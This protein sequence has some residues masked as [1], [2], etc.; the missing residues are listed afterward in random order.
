MGRHLARW[1]AAAA[2]PRLVLLGRTNRTPAAVLL[3]AELA[4]CGAGPRS[5]PATSPTG[6]SSAGCWP[7]SRPTDPVPAVFHTAGGPGRAPLAATPTRTA[8]FA[9]SWPRRWR[10]RPTWTTCCRPPARRVRPFLLH[11]R[12]LGQHG[13]AGYAAANAYLDAL[14]DQRR[15]RGRPATAVAWGVWADVVLGDPDTDEEQQAA[16]QPARP[17][18][19]AARAGAGRA[20]AGPGPTTT[21]RWSSPTWTGSGS[22]RCSPRREPGRCS[23]ICPTCSHS[24]LRRRVR[25]GR[26]RGH[27]RRPVGTRRTTGA[28]G[29]SQ[30][31]VSGS[32]A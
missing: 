16:A 9:V 4:A 32:P 8:R 28:N 25:A 11:L 26:R 23:A 24:R 18:R 5:A 2:A 10:A 6:T 31:L 27:A 21:P 7:K 14:A 3:T 19:D 13:Q 15:S 12:H 20:P 1:L 22:A 17:G 30:A 29:A